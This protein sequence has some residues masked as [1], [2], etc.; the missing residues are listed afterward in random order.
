MILKYLK[1]I[2]K[3]K[4]ISFLKENI[5]KIKKQTSSIGCR[6]L[7]GRTLISKK[8]N[9]INN[10]LYFLHWLPSHRTRAFMNESISYL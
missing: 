5:F 4:K 2:F 6:D 1:N 7:N 9:E 3:I 8:K 10:I